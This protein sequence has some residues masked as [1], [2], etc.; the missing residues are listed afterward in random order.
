[1]PSPGSESDDLRVHPS[2]TRTCP[3]VTPGTWAGAGRSVRAPGRAPWRFAS[4]RHTELAHR[5]GPTRGRCRYVSSLHIR[6]VGRFNVG[7][8]HLSRLYGCRSNSLMLYDPDGFYQMECTSRSGF[9]RL[10]SCT[11][12][13]WQRRR[14][15][16]TW[17]AAFTVEHEPTC[18]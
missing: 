9:Q 11:P 2:M 10:T 12:S 18:F 7:P 4:A 1:M 6:G 14:L 8:L 15:V 17:W 5:A 3:G 16:T 13:L